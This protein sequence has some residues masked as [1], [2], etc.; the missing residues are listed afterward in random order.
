MGL[1]SCVGVIK[2]RKKGA[3]SDERTKGLCVMVLNILKKE[4]EVE[5]KFLLVRNSL[6]K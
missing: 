5:R 1:L 6:V 2:T 4:K 3:R